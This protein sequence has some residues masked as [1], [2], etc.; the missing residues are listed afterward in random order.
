MKKEI[1][2]TVFISEKCHSY[3]V[4][5]ECYKYYIQYGNSPFC[6]FPSFDKLVSNLT[7]R[8]EKNQEY[9]PR[10]QMTNNSF[11]CKLLKE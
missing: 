4:I 9:E 7:N 1:K 3:N 11:I 2:R 5:P 10:H 8:T 6:L